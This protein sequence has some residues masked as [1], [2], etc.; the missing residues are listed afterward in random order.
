MGQKDLFGGEVAVAG[1][2]GEGFADGGSEGDL[3]VFVGAGGGR[4]VAQL[5]GLAEVAG[6]GCED[7]PEA[8]G[9]VDGEL[10][11]TGLEGDI[12]QDALVPAAVGVVDGVDHDVGALGLADGGLFVEVTAVVPAIGQDD[13]GAATELIAQF[14]VGDGDDGVEQQRAAAATT[15]NVVV[16][17]GEVGE[18]V[19]EGGLVGSELDELHDG[20][21]ELDEDGAVVW[22]GEHGGEE[23]AAGGNLVGD[24]GALRAAGVHHKGE[25][26]GKAG[27]QREVVDGL[28]LAVLLEE[29]IVAGEV[30]DG[31]AR[32]VAD[33]GRDGD[34]LGGDFKGSGVWRE[35][36]G[37]WGGFSGGRRLREGRRESGEEN[38]R[39]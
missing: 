23:D 19:G 7:L 39:E 20:A 31:L 21:V 13:H 3:V 4:T 2:D 28:G 35:G 34:K 32:L 11:A 24:I 5:V 18:A 10:A 33:D 16:G 22:P 1:L 25:G 36:R 8:A 17:L 37:G 6:D 14:E 29:E 30:G 38:E 12:A 9:G 15:D 27:S 26:E